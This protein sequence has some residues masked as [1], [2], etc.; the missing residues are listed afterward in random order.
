M[1]LRRRAVLATAA[2]VALAA[3]C[4][5][6]IGLGPL[7]DRVDG[8][9]VT[10]PDAGGDADAADPCA[11][12]VAPSRPAQDDPSDAD[13]TVVNVVRSFDLGEHADA[14]PLFGYDLDGVNTCCAD[15]PE[16]CVPPV[17][18]NK[19]CDLDGG[20]DNSGGALLQSIVQFGVSALDQN[21][22][23]GEIDAGIGSL[24]LIMRD[25]NGQPN[26]TQVS[27]ALYSST[28]LVHD[29]D[30]G[31]PPAN[32]DGNDTWM[33]DTASVLGLDDA[34][35]PVPIQFDSN[36]YV[37]NGVLVA[38]VSFPLV[39]GS[40]T[41]TATLSGAVVTGRL[42]AMNGTFAIDDG[43]GSGRLKVTNL[44]GMLHQLP[45]PFGPGFMCPG[46]IAYDNAKPIVC[47]H[48]DIMGDKTL[49][50]T[51]ATCDA[52]SLGLGFTTFPARVGPLDSDD[53]GKLTSTCADAAP[54]FCP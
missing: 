36:A 41:A 46:T 7:K 9:D 19:H 47:Q 30:G 17:P 2:L 52:L 11:L 39:F 8:G 33:V 5:D 31:R 42:V 29:A 32:W 13:V 48:A 3:G 24:L 51:G 49:D 10:V 50:N 43:Q 18:S 15:A 40:A 28:G 22:I 12:A 4:A 34:G 26:D 35:L 25:Y 54:D 27:L 16:S 14:G 20:R 53:G 38:I 1:V 37:S 21:N 6:L 45:N 23:N 44:F